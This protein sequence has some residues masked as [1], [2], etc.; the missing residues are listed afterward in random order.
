[1]NWL[2]GIHLLSLLASSSL[3][4]KSIGLLPFSI[5]AIIGFRSYLLSLLSEVLNRSVSF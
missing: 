2:T 5:S 4:G 3:A 1:M